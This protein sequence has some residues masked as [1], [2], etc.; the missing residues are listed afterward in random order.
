MVVLLRS[1][2]DLPE[3]ESEHLEN[4]GRCPVDEKHACV[5]VRLSI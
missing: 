1:N 3:L 4:K 2:R 5:R